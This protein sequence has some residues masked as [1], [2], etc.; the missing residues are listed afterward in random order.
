MSPTFW[1]WTLFNLC[2]VA[3]LLFDL[4]VL[5]RKSHDVK[6]KEALGWSAFWIALALLFC[7]GIW[8]YSGHKR[9][10]EFLAG[11][12]TEYSLSVDNI[13]VFILIFTYFKVGAAY[14]H[15]VLF[16]GILGAL[17]M[18]AVMIVAGVGLVHRF[19]WILY[20]F[21]AFLVFTGIRLAFHHDDDMDPGANPVVKLA[22]R[23]LPLTPDYHGN[24]FFVLQDGKRYATP[25]F[26]VLLVIETSDLLFAVDSIP[27]IIGLSKDPFIIYTSNV[28]A[29]LGLRSLYF[30]LAG[31]MDLFHYLK[32]ALS[33]ILTFVGV[34]MLIE[35][36][37]KIP[38]ELSLLIIMSA[39][40]ISILASLRWPPPPDQTSVDEAEALFAEEETES[41]T[42]PNQ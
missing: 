35:S 4:G 8:H 19:E 42:P 26:I 41:Q 25:L 17:V 28:F 38:I 34:K 21:G 3:L 24:R 10:L 27:A 9:A 36:F 15:K 31:I 37:Y 5:R 33:F 2:V 30:A 20:I 1:K 14:R 22:K 12:V 6:L 11:Y 7:G 23:F 18:R 16:W 40:V 32:Y 39:L 29:I 13:F